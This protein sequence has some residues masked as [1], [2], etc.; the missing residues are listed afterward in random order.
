MFVSE[1]V[2]IL[3]YFKKNG[4]LQVPGYCAVSS[5]CN[6]WNSAAAAAK[7]QMCAGWDL[8]RAGTIGSGSCCW[9]I[10]KLKLLDFFSRSLVKVTFWKILLALGAQI[11]G[12]GKGANLSY[13]WWQTFPNP[14]LG[15]Q[16]PWRA[17][18][19]YSDHVSPVFVPWHHPD[20]F[21]L[22]HITDQLMEQCAGLFPQQTKCMCY[23]HP[24][25]PLKI[26]L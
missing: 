24:P 19:I 11:V 5:P 16:K 12:E 20:K 4:L 23:Y 9:G 8:T 25:R 7:A 1:R 10:C 21:A 2:W 15:L 14:S 18:P 6:N 17:S 13:C 26:F 22:K 3:G